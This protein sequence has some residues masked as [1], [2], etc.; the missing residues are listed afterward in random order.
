[1]S[2]PPIGGLTSVIIPCWNQL[3]FTRQCLKS[4]IRRTAPRW[5]L[6][7][8]NNGST[9]GTG[10]YFAGVQD[11]SPVP[12][13]IIANATNRGF[14]AAINQGLQYARGE[15]LVLLNND[16]VVTDG[17]LEQLIALAA[18]KSKIENPKSKMEPI[19]LVGPM[20]NY[21]AP[22][23]L[24]ENVPYHD[25]EEMKIFAE[26]W[27]EEHLGQWS[28]T[29]KLSG[30]CLLMKRAVYDAIGGLDE[31]FGL[32]FF[33]DDDLAERARRA[34]F[35]LAVAHDLFVHHFGSRTFVG[36]GVDAERVL[37]ENAAKFVAQWGDAV[38]TGRR[39]ALRAWQNGEGAALGE[40]LQPPPHCRPS[41]REGTSSLLGDGLQ[42][43]PTGN[44]LGRLGAGLQ[45][46]PVS[47]PQVSTW[48]GAGLQPPPTGNG[49]GAGL[50]APEGSP[51]VPGPQVSA[52]LGDG[53]QRLRNGTT[54]SAAQPSAASPSAASDQSHLSN[55]SD[56]SDS[57]T[58]RAQMRELPRARVSLTM[59]VRDEENNLGR[60]LES[61]R[62]LFNEVVVLDTGSRDRTA[63]IA[64]SF[65]ARVF[66]FVWVDDF[67]AARNAAL[68]RAKGDYAFWL[69]AD[70]LIEP[71]QRA[72]LEE[73][74]GRLHAG[75]TMPAFVVRCS[76][77]PGP[78]G[79]GGDTVVDHI[80][81]F[82]LI[83]GV[84]WTYRVHEQ[85][86]LLRTIFDPC[87]GRSASA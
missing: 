63:E 8:I 13:T 86:L 74:L 64:R 62:D 54:I 1:M 78:D 26:R 72:K 66:D 61:V 3:E 77:D 32:G 17:W 30:F 59:I 65:G 85:I 28:T 2:A 60:C 6:I 80:R 10:D 46:P 5:E 68:A 53:L 58:R 41:L 4:L 56:P 44:G 87:G 38:P 31:R 40:G 25:L 52:W 50:R 20:S 21:A 83:E 82:P 23:Q 14:P 34:G 9:D 69:D 70:D 81:L 76:C 48:L 33:D 39:V 29:R 7:V 84:R 37:D 71:P 36:N 24:V 51:P 67:A 19:G 22:P 79:A 16:V 43:P 55:P 42:P 15:Y 73:L 35:E 18:A 11:I 45:T 12:V 47:R 57:Q 75:G 49:L 27:R